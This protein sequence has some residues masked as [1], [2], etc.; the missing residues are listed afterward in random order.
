[1]YNLGNFEDVRVF[2]LYKFLENIV[3]VLK[4]YIIIFF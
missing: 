4:I 2:R 3:W 1:M